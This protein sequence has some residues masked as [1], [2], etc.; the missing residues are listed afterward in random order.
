MKTKLKSIIAIALCA[1]GLSA[2]AEEPAGS[3]GNPWLVGTPN[4]ADVKAWTNGTGKLTI[5]GT[6]AMMDFEEEGSA[7]WD[8][9]KDTI[10]IAEIGSGVTNIGKNAFSGCAALTSVTIPSG[11][12]NIG[13]SAF[14]DC[15]GLSSVTIPSS[16]TSIDIYA[17]VGCSGLEDVTISSGVMSIGSQAFK[18]CSGL[19]SVTIPSSVT[20]IG[21]GAFTNCKG[22]K[23]VTIL[24]SVASI[25]TG[26]FSSCKAIAELKVQSIEDW[27]KVILKKD[28]AHPFAASTVSTPKLVAGGKEI[29]ELVIPSTITE[30]R[31]YTFL[32]NLGLT[33]VTI[34]SGVAS[35]GEYAFRD[36]SGLSSVTIP[37]SVTNIGFNAFAGFSEHAS[38]IVMRETPPTIEGATFGN[39]SKFDGTIYVPEGSVDAY[40]TA[41]GWDTYATKIFSAYLVSGV[42]EH[43]S[44]SFDKTCFPADSYKEPTEIVTVTATPDEGYQLKSLV[45]N[46]GTD[47]DITEAKSFTMPLKSVTVTAVFEAEQSDEE[48]VA[49][50]EATF[51]LGPALAV[52]NVTTATHWP[53]DGKIDVTCDLTG[54]GKVTLGAALTTNG[55]KV[56]TAKAENVTGATE[57][58]LDQVGGVTNGV[59]FTWNAKAD[60]PAGFNS[61]D[62]KVKV[63][64][65]KVEPQPLPVGALKGVFSVSADKKVHFSQGNLW[66]GKVGDAQTATFQFEAN[67][68]EFHGYDSANNTWGLFGWVGAS[69]TFTSSPEIYGVSTSTTYTDYGNSATDALKADWGTAIDDKGTWSTLSRTEWFYLFAYDPE[70]SDFDK[71]SPRYPL[72]KYGVTVC[73]KA[74]CV[75]LLPDKW[76]T[77]LIS[78]D[79]FASTTE[80]NEETSVK[81]SAMEAAGAV[82]LPAAGRRF[83]G[84]S[85]SSVGDKGYYWSSAAS[86]VR[87]A[88]SV[89][90]LSGNVYLNEDGDRNYG[91]S[92][93]LV[94][95]VK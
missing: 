5:E 87:R 9:V 50:D 62:T 24:S 78:L 14:H 30:I 10:I 67:Q 33:S 61:K 49:F 51:V 41:E 81:W 45:W 26:A 77:S 28:S 4:E 89:Y 69:S 59:K 58:D 93:R 7:P 60:C 22:L 44:L 23:S 63:T 31:G 18:S 75:V 15:S 39:I 84:S 8:S 17:F 88:Y 29:T 66:Y 20:N 13:E 65:K 6:G 95:E 91:Y 32:K 74:N 86:N 79:T 43:G 55:V 70:K 73:G 46:D 68:Y 82:C 21:S 48:V 85:A 42:A 34:P 64:A 92:V 94:T 47:H 76:D 57:I 71:T 40:K 53:W 38:V 25:D 83:G 11:V 90:F 54:S 1:V 19:T 12:T 80:Y 27:C 35:I 52:A 72:F 37:S 16:V 36:C 3:E 2:F 56:C